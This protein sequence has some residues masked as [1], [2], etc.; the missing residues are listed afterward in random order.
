L[1]L[2]RVLDGAELVVAD[3][4]QGAYISPNTTFSGRRLPMAT[5]RETEA[6]ANQIDAIRADMQNLTSTVSRIANAQ[7]NR[8]QGKAM[9]TA[10]E[11][12]DAIKR[13]PLQAVAIA[14]GLG[15]LFGVFTR[16]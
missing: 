14:A 11:A 15:F 10:Q 1:P 12:G 13:N 6:L 2:L 3:L 9:E 7:V 8:A 5:S 16:R 4:K